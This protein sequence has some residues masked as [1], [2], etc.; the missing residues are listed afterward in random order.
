ML[1]FWG[2]NKKYIHNFM[3][4]CNIFGCNKGET[5]NTPRKIHHLTIPPTIWI[6]IS[7]DFIFRIPKYSN[8]S[9][10]LGVV[11]RFSKHAYVPYTTFLRLSQWPNFSWEESSNYMGFHNVL[12]LI[13]IHFSLITSSKNYLGSN[14]P[15]CILALPI[16]LIW[17]SHRSFQQVFGSL[18]AVFHV[19]T[20]ISMGSM[21]T[22]F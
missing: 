21:V 8:K 19:K 9:F 15:N 14:A 3:V 12:S 1:L 20:M 13:V 5:M 11:D 10:I 22:I 4:E 7:M 17:W 16:N 2:W 6:N 18:F